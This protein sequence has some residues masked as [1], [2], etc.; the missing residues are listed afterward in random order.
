M[1]IAVVDDYQNAFRSLA[2]AQRL[3]GHEVVVFTTT[4]RDPHRFA[5][6][7]DGCDVLV[8]TQQR[9]P[10]PR[11]TI[12]LLPPSLRLIANT[13]RNLT[14]ID[15]DAC[16][17]R[18]IVV[19]AGGG[20]RSQAPAELTWALI[21]ASLRHITHEA[22]ALQQGQWQTTVGT[23]LFG[24]TLGIFGLGKIGSLVARVGTAFGMNVICTGRQAT[25]RAAAAAGYVVVD[26]TELCASADVL[27]L[28]LALTN[29]TR[30]VVTA[31]DLERMK[32]SALL[33][34]T[35]RADLI[36]PDALVAAL[37][38]GR[39]GFAAVDVYEDEPISEHPLLQLPNALCTPHLGYVERDTY[40]A[41]FNAVIDRILVDG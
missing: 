6:R 38:R 11:T 30:G 16:K 35:S 31:R 2:C 18:G 19:V 3:R 17:E 29:D 26:Q 20:G 7:L 33:V 36:E 28:H 23:G 37:Q 10:L 41:Y 5:E 8:L 39:P 13:G 1:K 32:P 27:S 22:N 15:L 34:N 4:Q 12:E 9:S 25:Q 40:E 24:K 14:H 21:L